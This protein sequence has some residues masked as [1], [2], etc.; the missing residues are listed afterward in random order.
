[1][2]E[3]RGATWIHG[4]AL[5][6]AG[7]LLASCSGTG[8]K[9][10]ERKYIPPA[11]VWS[12]VK[13][14]SDKHGLDPHFVYAICHAESSLNAHA[15]TSVARGIMQL[16]EAAWQDA[17]RGND[18]VGYD[19]AFD[20][21]VNVETGVRYLA[22]L[23]GMLTKAKKFTYQRLAASYRWGFSRLR[24]HGYDVSKLPTPKNRIYR[25]IFSGNT[26]PVTAPGK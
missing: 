25:K 16:T 9:E 17:T 8:T 26:R 6:T 7:I 13:K 5:A 19:L 21:E 22:K 3:M 18:K 15:E 14:E 1:M 10:R 2:R 20:W 12:K 23:K 4:V 11:K 24:S